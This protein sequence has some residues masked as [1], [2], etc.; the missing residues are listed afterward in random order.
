MESCS[1][2]SPCTREEGHSVGLCVGSLARVGRWVWFAS[3]LP[4]KPHLTGWVWKC[5][6]A[7]LWGNFWGKPSIRFHIDLYQGNYLYC[8]NDSAII[9]SQDPTILITT[10]YTLWSSALFLQHNV[11]PSLSLSLTHTPAGESGLYR[12]QRTC[13]EGGKNRP[14]VTP[15]ITKGKLFVNV[16]CGHLKSRVGRVC[17]KNSERYWGGG[18]DVIFFFFYS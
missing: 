10:L 7:G 17:G 15:F 9:S 18:Y 8:Q 2:H 12:L 13:S 5:L 11:W 14:K 4:L 6:A 16:V 3:V 1:C